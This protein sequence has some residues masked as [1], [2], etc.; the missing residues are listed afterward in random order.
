[1]QN[2][3]EAVASFQQVLKIESG[4]KAA[5]KQLEMC[6]SKQRSQREK[7][8]KLYSNMFRKLAQEDE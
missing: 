6:R 7:E 2:Y 1:M 5:V 8:K 3:E 4:N